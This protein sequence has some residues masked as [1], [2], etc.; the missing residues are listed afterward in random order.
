MKDDNS[1]NYLPYDLFSYETIVSGLDYP[2]TL[3]DILPWI[4]KD[5]EVVLKDLHLIS[6]GTQKSINKQ[7]IFN[8]IFLFLREFQKKSKKNQDILNYLYRE[9]RKGKFDSEN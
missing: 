4:E 6:N 8:I 2:E 3:K 9:M 1:V 5:L 7:A